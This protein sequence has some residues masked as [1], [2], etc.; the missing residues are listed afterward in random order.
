[1][2]LPPYPE[3]YGGYDDMGMGPPPRPPPHGGYD[4]GYRYDPPPPAPRFR[5]GPPPVEHQ[6]RGLGRRG[7]PME[8]GQPRM[9]EQRA[10][11]RLL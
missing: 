4:R 6:G 7:P 9:Q 1:M 10:P 3:Y 5:G 11:V 2:D 8:P